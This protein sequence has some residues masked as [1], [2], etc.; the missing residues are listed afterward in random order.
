MF[1]KQINKSQINEYKKKYIFDKQINKSQPQ[2]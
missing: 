2:G 1:N